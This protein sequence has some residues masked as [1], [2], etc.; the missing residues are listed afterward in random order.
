MIKQY[1]SIVSLTFLVLWIV[2]PVCC[3]AAVLKMAADYYEDEHPGVVLPAGRSHP[4]AVGAYPQPV[5]AAGLLRLCPRAG[6]RRGAARRVKVQLRSPL[7]PV[8]GVNI[9][10]VVPSRQAGLAW[11]CLGKAMVSRGDWPLRLHDWPADMPRADLLVC[12]W[13]R[14]IESGMADRW[15]WHRP[16]RMGCRPGCRWRHRRGWADTSRDG[17]FRSFSMNNNQDAPWNDPDGLPGAYLV[18]TINGKTTE[19]PCAR[20]SPG[21]RRAPC[22]NIRRAFPRPCCGRR[23]SFAGW[24]RRSR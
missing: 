18:M 5:G 8:D 7:A 17:R 14:F 24:T 15:G 22:W 6:R 4:S 13:P 19:R 16:I 1:L 11:C 2:I 9:R 3:R 10:K 23:R 21:I 12:T 20:S